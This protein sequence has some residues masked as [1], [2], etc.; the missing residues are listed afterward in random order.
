GDPR[1]PQPPRAAPV[2][3]SG[4]V[5]PDLQAYAGHIRSI[6]PIDA[7]AAGRGMMNSGPVDQVVRIVPLVASVQGQVV[8]SLG[9]EA[10]RVAADAGMRID[11]KGGGLL[12]IQAGELEAT[13][14]ADGTAWL[15]FGKHDEARFVSALEVLE[16]RVDPEMLRSKVV[17]LGVTG[18]GVLDFTT[19]PL[20]EFVPGVEIHAQV[21]ENLFNG[22]AL[23]RPALAP[24]MEAAALVLFG[25]LLI[26]FVPRMSALQ[27]IH[28]VLAMPVA[29]AGAGLIGF[30]HFHVLLDPLWPAV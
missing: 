30:V 13:S 8:P 19:T 20:G 7:A 4:D 29:L 18:L 28:V 23:A 26:V 3:L 1:F 9:V 25:L 10:L 27:G 22:V 12:S 17:L 14:Q 21:V 5:L 15:R 2:V 11:R 6:D 16:G 24:A